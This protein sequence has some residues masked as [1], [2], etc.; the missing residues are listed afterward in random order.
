MK[1]V[2]KKEKRK[3]LA[4]I[5]IW[6]LRVTKIYAE[7]NRVNN[8]LDTKVKELSDKNQKL[9][10]VD[11]ELENLGGRHLTRRG[12]RKIMRKHYLAETKSY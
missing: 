10:E 11:N 3:F 4:E 8:E 7:F 5:D 1:G 6:N 12:K 2:T 9:R